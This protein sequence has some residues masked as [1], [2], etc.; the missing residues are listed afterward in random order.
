M[1]HSYGLGLLS[2]ST[3]PSPRRPPAGPGGQR[4][5]SPTA[6]VVIPHCRFG[7]PGDAPS[8]RHDACG[9]GVQAVRR[10]PRRPT[11]ARCCSMKSTSR[12]APAQQCAGTTR[13]RPLTHEIAPRTCTARRPPTFGALP[14]RSA[15]RMSAATSP[16][17]A[18]MHQ[19]LRRAHRSLV[20]TPLDAAQ[21]RH[22]P[23]W[24]HLPQTDF[25]AMSQLMRGGMDSTTDQVPSPT[26]EPTISDATRMSESTADGTPRTRSHD[27][28][29]GLAFDGRAIAE[30]PP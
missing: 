11:R 26:S 1:T 8:E 14:A 10:P 23:E 28:D 27:P 4:S 29:R 21:P 3:L 18:N 24:L 15:S 25:S 12:G 17:P 22:Q 30:T 7:R 6:G 16:P 13:P 19:R 5:R 2:T 20:Q 9:G